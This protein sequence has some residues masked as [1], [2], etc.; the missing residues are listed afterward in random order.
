MLSLKWQCFK[1]THAYASI[2]V[3]SEKCKYECRAALPCPP[4]DRVR[5]S[6]GGLLMWVFSLRKI[7]SPFHLPKDPPSPAPSGIRPR[8]HGHQLSLQTSPWD[9]PALGLFSPLRAWKG[10]GKDLPGCVLLQ[11]LPF[12]E[13][14]HYDR[15]RHKCNTICQTASRNWVAL[16]W[17]PTSLPLI[18]PK[19]RSPT[20]GRREDQEALPVSRARAAS[21]SKM[22]HTGSA[23]PTRSRCLFGS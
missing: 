21:G 15:L 14:D 8:L 18:K 17:N 5:H 23:K 6:L 7:D 9:M 22:A 2:F 4:L 10:T 13:W 16:G 1:Q 3:P 19:C 12:E 11:A 20:P